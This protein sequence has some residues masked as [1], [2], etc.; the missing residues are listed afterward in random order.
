MQERTEHVH[1]LWTRLHH[2]RRVAVHVQ[3][4]HVPAAEHVPAPDAFEHVRRGAGRVDVTKA[5]D[6]CV[7]WT[8]RG[9]WTRGGAALVFRTAYRW[10]QI[11]G[12]ALRLAHLRHGRERPVHLV[13]LRPDGDAGDSTPGGT[14]CWRSEAPHPCRDDRYAATVRLR[15]DGIDVCWRITGPQKDVRLR[16]RY[17]LDQFCET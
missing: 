12:G 6:T 10:E 16:S 11:G 1:E 14:C 8:E 5:T 17:R 13:T 2:V 15:P 7:E 9:R 4:E 3:H